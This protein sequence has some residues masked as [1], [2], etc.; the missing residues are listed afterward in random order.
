MQGFQRQQQFQ[1][2]N[3]SSSTY[4]PAG[5]TSANVALPSSGSGNYDLEIT[6]SG[7][8]TAWIAFGDTSSVAAVIPTNGTPANGYVILGGQTKT[9]S[10]GQAQPSYIAAITAS[11]TT[12][13]YATIGQGA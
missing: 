12:V 4:V 2:A 9:I 8:V 10:I 6:N 1:P 11:S 5:I 13:L 3:G 7:T